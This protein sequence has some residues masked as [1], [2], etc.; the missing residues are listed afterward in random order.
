MDGSVL[1]ARSCD[2]TGGDDLMQIRAVPRMTHESDELI[3]IPGAKGIK[4]PQIKSTNA[5]VSILEVTDGVDIDGVNGGI[6]EFQVSA[7]ASSGGVFNEKTKKI[8]KYL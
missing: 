4:L 5:Y 3:E 8:C 1:V 7:G 2:S 6:N